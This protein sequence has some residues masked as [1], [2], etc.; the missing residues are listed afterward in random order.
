MVR[1]AHQ[2][3]EPLLPELPLYLPLWC[4]CQRQAG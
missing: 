3:R 4:P 1:M 2:P